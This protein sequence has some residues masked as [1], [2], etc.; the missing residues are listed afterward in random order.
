MPAAVSCSPVQAVDEDV[1]LPSHTYNST[2]STQE[3][4][5]GLRPSVPVAWLR[6]CPLQWPSLLRAV[7]PVSPELPAMV[8]EKYRSCQTMCFCG[9]F[10][11][12]RRA[13]ASIDN[14]LYLW[15]YDRRW[16]PPLTHTAPGPQCPPAAVA[17]SSCWMQW[18]LHAATPQ[19]QPVNA[20]RSGPCL[21]TR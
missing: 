9:V 7:S 14:C 10:P 6:S 1:C 15:R 11:E 13:W 18:L 20:A 3:S 5:Q 19:G 8:Q 2:C 4:T 16:V 17:C 21:V 12:I